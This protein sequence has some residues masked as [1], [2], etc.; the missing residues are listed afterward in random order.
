MNEGVAEDMSTVEQLVAEKLPPVQEQQTQIAAPY[1]ANERG[2]ITVE[3]FR[4]K[5]QQQVKLAQELVNLAKSASPQNPDESD[6]DY[7]MK[8]IKEVEDRLRHPGKYDQLTSQGNRDQL[9]LA[10]ANNPAVA[11]LRP[12]LVLMAVESQKAQYL[13]D[14][15]KQNRINSQNELESMFRRDVKTEISHAGEPSYIEGQYDHYFDEGGKDK[16]LPQRDLYA[17]TLIGD[18]LLDT[19]NP[20][21]A[22]QSQSTTFREQMRQLEQLVNSP[23]SHAKQKEQATQEL[24]R[25][26][27]EFYTLALEAMK[28]LDRPSYIPPNPERRSDHQKSLVHMYQIL[29]EVKTAKIEDLLNS[30]QGG[31]RSHLSNA[32]KEQ[33]R[34]L[35]SNPRENESNPQVDPHLLEHALLGADLMERRISYGLSE[36]QVPK[37]LHY[38]RYVTTDGDGRDGGNG[39]QPE[40]I[41]PPAPQ[42]QPDLPPVQP[43]PEP[44]TPTLPEEIRFGIASAKQRIEHTQGNKK[45]EEMEVLEER[46]REIARLQMTEDRTKWEGRLSFV[47]QFLPRFWKFSFGEISTYNKEKS[48]AQRLLAESGIQMT[49]LPHSFLQ[50]VDQLARQN[51][52][53]Q[54]GSIFGRIAG[55]TR[56]LFH[57]L[58]FRE[59]D[60]HRERVQIIRQLREVV[61]NPTREDLKT[62][63]DSN[64]QLV[65]RF[66]E[67]VTGDYH[68]SEQLAKRVSSEFGDEVIHHV[69]GEARTQQ[70]I[71]LS[72]EVSNFFKEY[73]LTPLVAE[74]INGPISPQLLT[75]VRGKIKEFFFDPK[76]I[77]WYDQQPAAVRDHLKLSLSYGTNLIPYIQETLLPQLRQSA[78]HLRADNNLQNYIDNLVLKVDVGTLESGQKGVINEGFLE[79]AGSRTITNQR[80]HQL[81][82]ELRHRHQAPTLVPDTYL[83][84]SVQRA[85]LIGDIARLGTNQVLWGI[86]AGLGLYATK[87]T[88]GMGGRLVV[89]VVG[90]SIVSG[91]FRAA[92]E[93]RVFNREHEEHEVEEELNYQFSPDARR[94]AEMARLSYQ[95][96]E[97]QTGL[98]DPMEQIISEIQ[99]GTAGRDRLIR[100]AGLVADTQARF[101]IMDTIG[102]GLLKATQHQAY[103][104]EKT[105]LEFARARAMKELRNYYDHN[106]AE[107]DALQQQFQ[108]E[109]IAPG[110]NVI[111]H[112]VEE[113]T[114]AQM[115][116]LQ[117]GNI[118][119]PRYDTALSLLSI[120]ERQSIEARSSAQTRARR[121]RMTGAFAS[122]AV[123]GALYAGTNIGI[124]ELTH[125]AASG[126]IG[127]LK[128]SLERIGLLHRADAS[129]S[130]VEITSQLRV[131][132]PNGYSVEHVS[133][134][135][136][137]ITIKAPDGSTYQLPFHEDQATGGHIVVGDHLPKNFETDEQSAGTLHLKEFTGFTPEDS[138][139]KDHTQILTVEGTK[140][141]LNLP[142]GYSA[143]QSPSGNEVI[144]NDGSKD[145]IFTLTKATSGKINFIQKDPYESIIPHLDQTPAS[146]HVPQFSSPEQKLSFEVNQ[147][148]QSPDA[149]GKDGMVKVNAPLQDPMFHT[150]WKGNNAGH[151]LEMQWGNGAIKFSG[152]IDKHAINP[153]I[154]GLPAE[155]D[156][157]LER[158]IDATPDKKITPDKLSV[159]MEL[160]TG[161]RIYTPLKLINGEYQVLLPEQF[162]VNGEPDPR[163]FK[164][165]GIAVLQNDK[166]GQVIDA[167][168]WFDAGHQPLPDVREHMLTSL[169]LNGHQ[170]PTPPSVVTPTEPAI[171]FGVHQ[172]IFADRNLPINQVNFSVWESRKT[173]FG[174]PPLLIPRGPLE[175]PENRR[176]HTQEGEI[177][178]Q[179]PDEA[180]NQTEL[181]GEGPLTETEQPIADLLQRREQII[182]EFGRADREV[183]EIIRQGTRAGAQE[184]E[185]IAKVETRNQLAAQL[186]ILTSEI[187]RITQE[188]RLQAEYPWDLE[189][190]FDVIAFPS[191]RRNHPGFI[192]NPPTSAWQINPQELDRAINEIPLVTEPFFVVRNGLVSANPRVIPWTEFASH[193]RFVAAEV[194]TNG[195]S[196][197][198]ALCS[199]L[200][201]NPQKQ[202]SLYR[203]MSGI[204]LTMHEQKPEVLREWLRQQTIKP[205]TQYTREIDS[206]LEIFTDHDHIIVNGQRGGLR[207]KDERLLDYDGEGRPDLDKTNL[208]WRDRLEELRHALR[209]NSLEGH[210]LRWIEFLSHS[211]DV[212][213]LLEFIK[214]HQIAPASQAQTPQPQTFTPSTT[215]P[216][217]ATNGQ[218]DLGGRPSIQRQANQPVDSLPAQNETINNDEIINIYTG[219]LQRERGMSAEEARKLAEAASYAHGAIAQLAE[220]ILQQN[221]GMSKQEAIKEAIE[222]LKHLGTNNN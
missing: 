137:L 192:S 124:N 160:R 162:Q 166:T 19:I 130:P 208:L 66:T 182:N 54:R 101:H 159:I 140:F 114:V 203:T 104:D 12:D 202:A 59:K 175:A 119:D 200:A 80:V 58:T 25:T 170:L 79:R 75:Q 190:R 197:L 39:K 138:L 2:T 151:E 10:I 28:T 213:K 207:P 72:P 145:H 82:E 3:K 185:A 31:S 217:G 148:V 118:L 154:A 212:A 150:L 168:S 161:E 121:R 65:Q 68:A 99:A 17:F 71:E 97:M 32:H 48:H 105:Q 127:W 216:A 133:P 153:H 93:G 141:G 210:H 134:S 34:Q 95:K 219:I 109:N 196:G 45:V 204:I 122:T 8:I 30:Y 100:L 42:H 61:N 44:D 76:F 56:D 126:D 96:R 158:L 64:P 157:M 177:T 16:R 221:P 199:V 69:V 22:N 38:K 33:M 165:I 94:R 51:I 88:L 18:R 106:Q 85:D 23:T 53:Q 156:R 187:N 155:H 205:E 171:H 81:Y 120:Q 63:A 186:K 132:V 135:D 91:I 143:I 136:H 173:N 107:A 179:T 193:P 215:G 43:E 15:N 180:H 222:R 77:R 78:E 13:E 172:P 111:D 198:L 27:N 184:Q 218:Q 47:R 98:T 181:N 194:S 131:G 67:I 195:D 55:G 9:Y 50:E 49:T 163:V 115:R 108:I 110:R 52:R 144:I 188:Q 125:H 123:F 21:T 147:L 116:H 1:Y 5:Y 113:L 220:E 57:E 146:N 29:R 89:P 26:R 11:R 7:E 112:L 117:T 191:V 139:N 129:G 41:E 149:L 206:P 62:F 86:G 14:L 128:G 201:E 167:S 103:Q 60:L 87:A 4:S 35:L 102:Y 92:Q 209:T 37:R 164:W 178:N 189:E 183:G 169:T 40:T 83:E 73:V 142:Y 70:S 176:Q 90:G 211:A 36:H 214:E 74:G 20:A 6:L 84:A 152:V 46:S 24:V 174:F